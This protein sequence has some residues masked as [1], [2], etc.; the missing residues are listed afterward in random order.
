[1]SAFFSNLLE[2]MAGGVGNE[3]I[4]FPGAQIA[5]RRVSGYRATRLVNEERKLRKEGRHHEDLHTR[6]VPNCRVPKAGSRP[7]DT[8]PT[9]RL[10]ETSPA[11]K[12]APEFQRVSVLSPGRGRPQ[13][14]I[15]KQS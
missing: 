11:L 13:K 5:P 15:A 1:M 10:Q 7:L 4:C 12:T 9:D 6:K 3:G 14:Q 8:G 2:S